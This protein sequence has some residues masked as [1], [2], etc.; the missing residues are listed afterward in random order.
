[1][2]KYYNKSLMRHD[3]SKNLE[4]QT[5]YCN[6]SEYNMSSVS[7]D[8]NQRIYTNVKVKLTVILAN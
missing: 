3:M 1:M 5:T 8:P 4:K 6:C 2:L 7:H